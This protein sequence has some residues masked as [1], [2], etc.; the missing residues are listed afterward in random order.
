MLFGS[1]K[2]VWNFGGNKAMMKLKRKFP[3]GRK[4]CIIKVAAYK[5]NRIKE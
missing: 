3:F 1:K 4:M 2:E 5:K